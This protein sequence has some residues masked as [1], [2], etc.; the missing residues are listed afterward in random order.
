MITRFTVDNYKSLVNF[1]YEPKP[2]E[3]IIGANGSGKT[4]ML[5][6]LS[7][8]RDFV[9]FGASTTECFPQ[10]SLTRWQGK[11]VEEAQSFVIELL[12]PN[13]SP[14]GDGQKLRYVLFI[15]HE[16][17]KE[18]CYVM[19]EVLVKGLESDF[20]FSFVEGKINIY[21]GN[22]DR[23][24]GPGFPAL[25][26]R[27]A[28]S[29]IPEQSSSHPLSMFRHTLREMLLVHINPM[30]M[31]YATEKETSEA[32]LDMSNFPSWYRHHS[33]ENPAANARLFNSL[34]EVF[35]DF[36]ALQLTSTGS[37]RR[38]LMFRTKG[39][40][41]APIYRFDELSDGQR[42]LI[43]LYA[44]LHFVVGEGGIVCIDEPE[45]F[46]ALRELQP[47]LFEMQDKVE[48]SGGQVLLISHNPEFINQMAPQNA[49]Q[50][51]R[52]DNL[53]TVVG[54][55]KVEGFDGLTPA[56]VVARGWNQ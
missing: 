37:D 48:E 23:V 21:E 36:A 14:K 40:K 13:E 39:G 31:D 32:S 26:S 17:E 55:F 2:V 8:L 6:A 25:Q 27:S 4:T 30:Q 12:L 5:E 54:P 50:F 47:W 53:Q 35:D 7:R 16:P 41:K 18:R 46:I 19:S 33:Q 56:E 45:N 34:S 10:S 42:T 51:S 38:E 15:G 28:L 24:E 52:P 29:I 1:I 9:C 11:S 22:E 20:L 43:V 49:V 44:L 3:L